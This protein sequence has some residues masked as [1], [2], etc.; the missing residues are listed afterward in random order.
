MRVTVHVPTGVTSGGEV[1]RALQR[2][3]YRARVRHY[4]AS[5]DYIGT[6]SAPAARQQIGWN[7]W[8]ADYL[9]PAGFLDALVTCAARPPEGSNLPRHCDRRLDRGLDRAAAGSLPWRQAV[10]RIDRA[11]TWLPLAHLRDEIAVGDRAHDVMSHPV[12]GLMLEQ[13]WVR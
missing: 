10:D 7:G 1:A 6:V 12:E 11:A 8:L 5:E 2:L 4:A 9:T 3:G 13:I